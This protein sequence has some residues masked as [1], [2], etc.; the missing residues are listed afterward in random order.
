MRLFFSNVSMFQEDLK[1][2]DDNIPSSIA[3]K[4]LVDD[5]EDKEQTELERSKML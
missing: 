5:E 3:D 4:L 1:W 2:I